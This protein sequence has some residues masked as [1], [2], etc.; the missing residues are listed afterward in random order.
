MPG[1]RRVRRAANIRLPAA[2]TARRCCG[3]RAQIARIRK[4][5]IPPA[6]VESGSVRAPT[7]TCRPPGATR[8]G[9]S[10]TV[11][12]RLAGGARH[13]DKFDRIAIRR[14]AEVRRRIP[15]RVHADLKRGVGRSQREPVLAA[16]VRLLDTTLVRIGND[17][18]VRSNGSY[19]LPRCATAMRQCRAAPCD[20][21]F[22]GKHGIGTTSA[23]GPAGARV[24]AAL[25]GHARAGP[26]RVRRRSPARCR[27]R[28]GRRQRTIC[29]RRS[30]A[31]FT[32]KD[33]RTLACSVL[34]LQ[35]MRRPRDD[36]GRAARGHEVLAEVA[37]R[38]GNTVAVCRKRMCI[39]RCWRWRW[40]PAPAAGRRVGAARRNARA[41]RCR[42]GRHW[43]AFPGRHAER[44][45]M[46]L[47]R[48]TKG[49]P[50]RGLLTVRKRTMAG[51]IMLKTYNPSAAAARPSAAPARACS[52]VDGQ[53]ATGARTPS[54][55]CF[56]FHG[57]YDVRVVYEQ[58]DGGL[59]E[60]GGFEPG[61]RGVGPSSLP[62]SSTGL[63][64]AGAVLRRD[65]QGPKILLIALYRQRPADA[66]AAL[67]AGFGPLHDQAGR[68]QRLAVELGC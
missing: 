45:A 56:V 5:A 59:D 15:P 53:T 68:G 6:L 38:L 29:A 64:A 66:K 48:A 60:S 37:A 25:P 11:P 1:F 24:G 7:A 16:L 58:R 33:F 61:R 30:G 42:M 49:G 8:A 10:S 19:G 23:R 67:A 20:L 41:G 28:L 27:C 35:L 3:T 13:A 52:I 47:N 17:E 31:D 62:G 9:A 40:I 46:R 39:R 55:P 34:A 57:L 50:E 36:G 12:P 54:A 65:G 51:P 4:L 44:S 63:Q 32:A 26:V 14:F 22:R 21:R 2:R 43:L 18:Y